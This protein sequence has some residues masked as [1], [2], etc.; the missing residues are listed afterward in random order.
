MSSHEPTEETIWLTP[1]GYEQLQKELN[2]LSTTRRQEIA[3]RIRESKEHGEFA[4]DNTELEDA[5]REQGIVEG[6]IIELKAILAAAEVLSP[7]DVPLRTAGIGSLV[8][9]RNKR[10]KA[11]FTLLLVSS[12]EADPDND[13]IS[14]ASPLGGAL[15][16]AKKGD[17]V[18]V[19]AP[20]GTTSYEVLKVS[21]GIKKKKAK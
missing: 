15:L 14:S 1:E 18:R 16:G 17:V 12:V 3:D 9:V 5:K 2:F 10:T 8:S 6:R 20:G 4:D 13:K 21:R 7:D 11:E 19:E